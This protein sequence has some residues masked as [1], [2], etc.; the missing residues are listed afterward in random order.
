[1]DTS[2]VALFVGFPTQGAGYLVYLPKLRC[3]QVVRDLKLNEHGLIQTANQR[4]EQEFISIL[5]ET[6]QK[7]TV[8]EKKPPKS[9]NE[10]FELKNK[11]PKN[12][13]RSQASPDQNSPQ[14]QTH[15]TDNTIQTTNNTKFQTENITAR[16]LTR[17][18][19]NNGKIP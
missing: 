18:T 4:C 2:T 12:R 3:F 17:L 14:Q 8:T 16:K 6:F 10:T 19:E 9:T 11:A 1:M 13:K 5:D 7:T 15:P